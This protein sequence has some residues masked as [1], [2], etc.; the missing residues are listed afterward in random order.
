MKLITINVIL[1]I[2]MLFNA[3]GINGQQK[4]FE[5]KSVATNAW[6]GNTPATTQIPP[7]TESAFWAY[8]PPPTDTPVPETLPPQTAPVVTSVPDQDAKPTQIQPES[9][10]FDISISPLF[11][12]NSKHLNLSWKL[13][14][15]IAADLS[16]GYSLL[17]SNAA[18]PT[19]TLAN[20]PVLD[21]SGKNSLTV[22]QGCEDG[23][24]LHVDLINGG[25]VAAGQD[26]QIGKA[27]QF[28]VKQ[29]GGEIATRDGAIKVKIDGKS[30]DRDATFY[31]LDETNAQ[32]AK[33][34]MGA[35]RLK[36]SPKA[37]TTFNKSTNSR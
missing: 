3:F 23:C 1:A 36:L 17:V 37:Q 32:G 7:V 15:K 4:P 27:E 35:I 29:S 34:S 25:K 13:S 22:S 10:P 9:T 16:S 11:L 31:I 5:A 6:D 12:T 26:V 8:P 28:Q 18:E 21:A 30:L 14:E 2:T 24:T 20:L 33:N 19:A